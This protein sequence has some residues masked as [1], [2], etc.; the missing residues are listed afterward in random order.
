MFFI[1]FLRR[2]AKFN[3]ERFGTFKW[4][5]L[6]ILVVIL[7]LTLS[8]GTGVLYLILD[9]RSPLPLLSLLGSVYFI[10]ILLAL[11]IGSIGIAAISLFVNLKNVDKPYRFFNVAEL[12][13]LEKEIDKGQVEEQAEQSNLAA[14]FGE[15]ID[16]ETITALGGSGI[17]G[18]GNGVQELVLA[19]R[20]K[21]F[22]SL[23][24]IDIEY[25]D[26]KP[27]QEKATNVKLNEFCE[28]FRLYLADVEGLYYDIKSIRAFVSSFASSRIVILEGLSGTGKSSLPRYFC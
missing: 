2:L 13:D 9:G 16:G 26:L 3:N 12:E 6:S 27:K 18:T 23:S 17:A 15:A 19:D 22:P 4:I 14:Q 10:T 5:L 28:D 20:E 21:V 1:V 7:S 8:I 24:S 25:G 11:F